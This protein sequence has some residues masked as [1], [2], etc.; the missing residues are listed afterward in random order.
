MRQKTFAD[1][2]Y[3][4]KKRKTRREKFLE[5]ME[6]LIPWKRLQK[7]IVPFYAKGLRGRKPYPLSVM[8]RIHCVQLFYNLSDPA[9][10]DM[11]YEIESIRRFVG[12][13]WM[14]RFRMRRRFSTSVTHSKLTILGK[15]CLLT[16][17][18]IWPSRD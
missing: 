4:A 16:S 9:M 8:F 2:D 15:S 6:E 7:R 13:A 5:R 1:V 12:S 14:V 3:E 11:L 18:S 10:E 17:T